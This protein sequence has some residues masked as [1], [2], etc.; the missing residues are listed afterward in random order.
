MAR[1]PALPLDAAPEKPDMVIVSFSRTPEHFAPNPIKSAL[2]NRARDGVTPVRDRIEGR[3][4]FEFRAWPMH[5]Q[6]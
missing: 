5:R 3:I 1:D 2:R 4:P 6:T